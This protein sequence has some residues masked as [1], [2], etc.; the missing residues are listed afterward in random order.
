MVVTNNTPLTYL[1]SQHVLSRRHARWLKYLEQNFTYKWEY[2]PWR[3]NIVDDLSRNHLG[4]NACANVLS[5]DSLGCRDVRLRALLAMSCFTLSSREM[6]VDISNGA[7][8]APT[9]EVCIGFDCVN[10]QLV[11]KE[12]LFF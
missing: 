4:G 8:R 12:Q 9:N 6:A 3:I 7:S 5:H 1:K 10:E 2:T 11:V